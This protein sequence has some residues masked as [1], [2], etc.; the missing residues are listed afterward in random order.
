MSPEFP[1]H[2]VILGGG[3]PL[4]RPGG[5]PP[6][7]F[8][9]GGDDSAGPLFRE[10]VRTW[11]LRFL[12]KTFDCNYFDWS[13][14]CSRNVGPVSS[15]N[16]SRPNDM[17]QRPGPILCPDRYDSETGP[18][19]QVPGGKSQSP[20]VRKSFPHHAGK[21]LGV[22]DPQLTVAFDLTPLSAFAACAQQLPLSAF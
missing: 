6:K 14:L 16:T 1:A 12:R 13:T 20:S 22:L 19:L 10:S 8:R 7:L 2:A 9:L 17:V 4:L 5:Y 15:Y 3:V 21:E 18:S 11:F